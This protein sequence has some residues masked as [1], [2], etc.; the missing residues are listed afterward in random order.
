MANAQA[1]AGSGIA[2]S[3]GGASGS[4]KSATD[5]TKEV[6]QETAQQVQEQVGQKAQEVRSQ[7]G[8]RVRDEL[9]TRSTQAG[10]QVTATANAIRRV[11]QQLREEGQEAPAKYAG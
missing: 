6:V 4:G 10:E 1:T 3:G 2:G 8:T 5:Q 9:D 7:A 11:S